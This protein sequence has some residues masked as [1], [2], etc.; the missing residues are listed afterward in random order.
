ML[1]NLLVIPAKMGILT[2]L[3][4][5]ML[6]EKIEILS[7]A[8]TTIVVSIDMCVGTVQGSTEHMSATSNIEGKLLAKYGVVYQ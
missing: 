7:L 2:I 6:V 4:H 8:L 3:T 1:V 5:E